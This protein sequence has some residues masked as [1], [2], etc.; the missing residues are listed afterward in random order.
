MAFA[1]TLDR[2]ASCIPMSYDSDDGRIDGR[3]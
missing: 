2:M 3:K 1:A